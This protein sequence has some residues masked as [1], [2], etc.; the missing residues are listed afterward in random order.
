MNSE[1]VEDKKSRFLPNDEEASRRY[2]QWKSKDPFPSIQPALLNSADIED[3][4]AVTGMLFPFNRDKLK[5]ASYEVPLEGEIHYWDEKGEKRE[6]KLPKN[7]TAATAVAMMLVLT[8]TVT[9]VAL[10]IASAHTPPWSTPTFAF[11][12]VT[13][14]PVGANQA[15]FVNF[16]LD[17]VPPTANVAF[18]DRW[19]NLKVESQSLT[20]AWRP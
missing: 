13:P 18:G 9:M 1:K 15:L 19:E 3:Y 2:K 14:S 5:S 7:R 6:M 4:V 16:W 10:P 8:I 11:L 20:E 12:S 17:K